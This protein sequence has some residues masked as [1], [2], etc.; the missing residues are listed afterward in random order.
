M[1]LD[2]LRVLPDLKWNGKSLSRRLEKAKEQ[3][4]NDT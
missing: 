3:P 2:I 4:Q 1:T